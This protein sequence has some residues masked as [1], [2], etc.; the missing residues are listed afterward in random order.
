MHCC[1]Y[2]EQLLHEGSTPSHLILRFRQLR[3]AVVTCFCFFD[4]RGEDGDA[5]LDIE[6]GWLRGHGGQ[7]DITE[8][9]DAPI[10]EALLAGG[11]GKP[12]W[13]C[14]VAQARVMHSFSEPTMFS[15]GILANKKM[16]IKS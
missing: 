1:E 13:F 12:A 6:A 15:H 16:N 11:S 4:A 14:G 9:D 10:G 2:S 8:L 3:H 5:A 7:D